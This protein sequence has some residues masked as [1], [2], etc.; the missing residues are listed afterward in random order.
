[1][2]SHGVLRFTRWI[3]CLSITTVILGTI[4]ALYVLQL[5]SSAFV[6]SSLFSFAVMW[7]TNLISMAMNAIYWFVR[8]GPKG[9]SVTLLIQAGL[10]VAGFLALRYPNYLFG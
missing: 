1:M 4:F 8:R 3:G 9:L 2:I 10:T 7:L 5:P 6:P